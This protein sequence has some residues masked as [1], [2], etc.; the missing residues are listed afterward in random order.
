[1][2]KRNKHK[3]LIMLVHASAIPPLSLWN[4]TTDSETVL[5]F[6]TFMPLQYCDYGERQCPG[7]TSDA[8]TSFRIKDLLH[9]ENVWAEESRFEGLTHVYF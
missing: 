6:Q 2:I 5:S 3:W 8:S 9:F 7:F 4:W 1:M